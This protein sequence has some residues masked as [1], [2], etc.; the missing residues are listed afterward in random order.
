MD[1]PTKFYLVSING[2][3]AEINKP[4]DLEFDKEYLIMAADIRKQSF[5]I[6]LVTITIL[7][8]FCFDFGGPRIVERNIDLG[9]AHSTVIDDND[10]WLINKNPGRFS[11][12]LKKKNCGCEYCYFFEIEETT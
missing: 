8:S 2:K 7:L 1:L 5:G 3:I 10:V 12:I 9:L 4:D 6:R 11:L